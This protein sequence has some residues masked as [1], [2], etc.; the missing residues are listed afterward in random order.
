MLDIGRDKKQVWTTWQIVDTGG[1]GTTR[2]GPVHG[3]ALH[4]AGSRCQKIDELLPSPSYGRYRERS[5]PVSVSLY[6]CRCQ[7]ARVPVSV[8]MCV[9][10]ACD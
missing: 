7:R 1:R 3:N 4:P 8:F 9:V 2:Q 5:M 10:W 6:T